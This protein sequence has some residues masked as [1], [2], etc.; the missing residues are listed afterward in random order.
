MH[1]LMLEKLKRQ[2]AMAEAEVGSTGG[3]ACHIVW[4]WV[5]EGPREW[6]RVF[7]NS[8]AGNTVHQQL[9]LMEAN[10]YWP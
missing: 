5:S 8:D 3:A 10:W 1:A 2:E 9:W 4:P 7:G 6:G